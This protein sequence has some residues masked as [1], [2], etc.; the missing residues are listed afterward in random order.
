MNRYEKKV[1]AY[2]TI[3][4]MA[5]RIIYLISFFFIL[6]LF[7]NPGIIKAEA[8]STGSIQ[9]RITDQN[10][11]PLGNIE[12]VAA[13]H[14][15]NM[16]LTTLF[17]FSYPPFAT[18]EEVET[19]IAEYYP[20]RYDNYR[21]INSP[22]NFTLPPMHRTTSHNDGTFLLSD[23][24]PGKYS[25]WAYDPLDRGFVPA[26]L[27]IDGWTGPG[28]TQ[29]RDR[30]QKTFLVSGYYHKNIPVRVRAGEVV[31]PFDL[32]MEMGGTFT[33]RITDADSD[34]PIAGAKIGATTII[35][36][37][38]YQYGPYGPS[39]VEY[40]VVTSDPEGNFILSGLPQG[41]YRL[42]VSEAEGY[43]MKEDRSSLYGG[44]LEEEAEASLGESYPVLPGQVISGYTMTLQRGAEIF[45]TITNQAN[46]EPVADVEV[47]SIWMRSGYK[48]E[49]RK[50]RSESDGTY[51]F[52]GLEDGAYYLLI[53]VAPG[54]QGMYHPD[55]RD[56]NR[57]QKI[58]VKTREK[59]GPINFKLPPVTSSGIIKGQIVE[60]GTGVPLPGIK[61]DITRLYV[62]GED[63]S[64]IP[65]GPIPGSFEAPPISAILPP[66]SLYL[67]RSLTDSEGKFEFP[68]LLSGKYSL[69]ISDPTGKHLPFTYPTMGDEWPALR[70][71]NYYI[72][73]SE[74]QEITD[75][76]IPLR[77]GGCLEGRVMDGSEPLAG[78]L[79]K[80]EKVKKSHFTS[81]IADHFILSPMW[82]SIPI[83][84]LTDTEGNFSLCGLEEGEYV[85]W[86]EDA[87]DRGCK[88]TFYSHQDKNKSAPLVLSLPSGS[89]IT[90]ITIAMEIGATIHG[91]V[92]DTAGNPLAIIPVE[93][94]FEDPLAFRSEQEEQGIV[95][96]QY[97]PSEFRTYT[98]KEGTYTL[99]GLFDG[100]YALIVDTFGPKYLS[101]CYSNIIISS[102][103]DTVV[104]IVLSVGGSITG[105]VTGADGRPLSGIMVR[106]PYDSM[107]MPPMDNETE[108]SESSRCA[109][110]YYTLFPP[111]PVY[112]A[113]DGTYHIKGF[114]EGDY[115]IS[116]YDPEGI[117]LQGDYPLGS[118]T[119][120][121]GEETS[122]VDIK[123][124]KGGI[125]KG[126]IK[127]QATGS[128]ISGVI[129]LAEEN[130]VA[131]SAPLEEPEYGG[132]G[133]PPWIDPS[134]GIGKTYN[135][136]PSDNE[137]RYTIQ[138]LPEGSYVV[139]IMS[140]KGYQ[141]Q[142][143]SSAGTQEE[144]IMVA[145]SSAQTVDKIDF[146][147]IQ[148]MSPE[149]MMQDAVT[150]DV[151]ANVTLAPKIS[152]S[153]EITDEYDLKP[154]GN[155][156][157]IAIPAEY[158][159]RSI[160]SDGAPVPYP[161]SY[162]PPDTPDTP[163]SEPYS[164]DIAGSPPV[165]YGGGVPYSPNGSYKQLQF[166]LTDQN[167][168]YTVKNLE[169]G[170]WR[171]L[172]FDPAYIYEGEYY[173]D[174]APDLWEQATI[175]HIKRSEAPDR[176]DMKLHVGEIY[177]EKNEYPYSLL[178]EY[179]PTVRYLGSTSQALSFEGS[180]NFRGQVAGGMYL[181]EYEPAAPLEIVS[182]AVDQVAV[183]RNF[184]YHVHVSDHDPD[185]SIKYALNKNPSGMTIDPE[186]GII[187]WQPTN[188]DRGSS[189]VQ[190]QVHASNDQVFFKSAFQSFR[191][192]VVEDR[193]PPEDIQNLTTI[194][195]APLGTQIQLPLFWNYTN[196]SFWD[197]ISLSGNASY[198]TTQ[199]GI[200]GN[201][202][203]SWPW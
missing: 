57:A 185:I 80:F 170:D 117:Y 142:Y 25:L 49:I 133:V 100:E 191:L 166:A 157:V 122:N 113:E 107:P 32:V 89:T 146:R 178:G 104:D 168:R 99:S 194:P 125:I 15:E 83:E 2:C 176:I 8:G 141:P 151:I 16:K 120:I 152:L 140:E 93:L 54:F 183:G 81:S 112:T 90:G 129:V 159:P 150:G 33:G 7:I 13:E 114:R 51:R 180:G 106:V 86:A 163:S 199:N 189:I 105:K 11:L 38:T 102:S 28:L 35:A 134:Q 59:V 73:L 72:Q 160:S 94:Y 34:A 45:G 67:P 37:H 85:I 84:E 193:I 164:S 10:G 131:V 148:G 101:N 91:S 173:K 135:S 121:E 41:E 138:G 88:P 201:N 153:G 21:Y 116:A 47:Q 190:V 200:L 108:D 103:D 95:Y 192:E 110:I 61:V 92:V 18:E 115:R 182:E 19:M 171:I 147:L 50:A 172:V 132:Y 82:I 197:T 123:L 144:A 46:G 53:Q 128:P 119:V 43:I 149:G 87:L 136:T 188:E 4:L 55:T 78:A 98:W 169:E 179:Q 30:E 181:S 145:V 158:D 20:Y 52:T 70:Y 109:Y 139:H 39:A 42:R 137:G 143:Y 5:H 79:V 97:P 203:S 118:V 186:S 184:I 29:M 111:N 156:V 27:G 1:G 66:L 198:F 69:F 76:T 96:P 75:I 6:S 74:N 126:I 68:G 175:I 26:I 167:G 130:P 64:P 202:L 165:D 162:C 58:I 155:L 63:D 23:I 9:G 48:T 22:I 127:D 174:V 77:R 124:V 56:I 14:P 161:A 177:A 195:H 187:E 196:M 17:P 60:E 44:P 65:I 40:R 36:R 62:Q 154:L 12:I 3:K 71:L 24:P 31:G